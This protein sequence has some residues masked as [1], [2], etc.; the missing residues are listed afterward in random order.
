MLFST[1]PIFVEFSFDRRIA[2][3]ET[4]RL[5]DLYP[6]ILYY[7]WLAARSQRGE[8]ATTPPIP[9]RT[10]QHGKIITIESNHELNQFFVCRKIENLK[11]K[12]NQWELSLRR[13]INIFARITTKKWARNCRCRSDSIQI[14]WKWNSK[15][16]KWLWNNRTNCNSSPFNVIRFFCHDWIVSEA[17]HR[18][19][20]PRFFVSHNIFDRRFFALCNRWITKIT[21]TKNV[22]QIFEW[23]LWYSIISAR[24][25]RWTEH[26]NRRFLFCFT[27]LFILI[28]VFCHHH[29]YSLEN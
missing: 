21:L 4:Y 15:E 24:K 27:F 19:K 14:S 8:G 9:V 23:V 18:Q 3:T 13:E 7:I 20:D 5:D 16:M 2:Y 6:D 11:E 17:L 22:P 29:F 1:D 28:G 25:S 26:E 12:T 10:K